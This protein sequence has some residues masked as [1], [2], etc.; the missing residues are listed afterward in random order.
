MHISETP[1]RSNAMHSAAPSR[2]GV[3][4]AQIFHRRLSGSISILDGVKEGCLVAIR[5]GSSLTS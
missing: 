2:G 5:R 4:W 1:K 3:A